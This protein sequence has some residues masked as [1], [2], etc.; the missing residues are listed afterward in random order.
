[1]AKAVVARVAGVTAEEARAAVARVAESQ[2]AKVRAGLLLVHLRLAQVPALAA[3]PA[4]CIHMHGEVDMLGPFTAM[5][6]SL[7]VSLGAEQECVLLFCVILTTSNERIIQDQVFGTSRYGS[8]YPYGA[9]G[10][11][12]GRPFP[13]AF[14]PIPVAVGYFGADTVRN[15][16]SLLSGFYLPFLSIS[17]TQTISAPVGT[18][19]F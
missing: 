12:S 9:S 16:L 19:K 1:M 17:T 8:G 13:F 4:L 14:W 6:P 15:F 10:D 3:H 18:S 2:A 11:V 7:V 5:S